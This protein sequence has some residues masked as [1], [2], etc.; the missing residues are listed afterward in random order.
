MNRISYYT[1]SISLMAVWH[2]SMPLAAQNKSLRQAQERPNVVIILADDLGIGDVSAFNE[3]AA[4]KTP[5]IDQ[6]AA[7]G[8]SFT[9][10]HTS[11]ALCTPTRYGIMTGR[12]NWRSTLKSGGYNGYSTPLIE[13]ERPPIAELFKGQG[14]SLIHN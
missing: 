11:A 10:A 7:R 14:L 9:D 12:Y 3:N 8:M 5:N 2:L 1:L 6:I 4:W 13:D